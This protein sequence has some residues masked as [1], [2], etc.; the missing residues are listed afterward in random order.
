[1]LRTGLLLAFAL[2]TA[3]VTGCHDGE[4]PAHASANLS[5][6]APVSYAD[7]VGTWQFVYSDARRAAVEADLAKK[8]SDPAALA[9]AKKE[10]AEEAAA[11]E[12]ELTREG[13]FLSRVEGKEILATA[14][15][16]KGTDD[17]RGLVLTSPTHAEM[18]M[19][20]VLRDASTLIVSDP[21]KGELV[22]ARR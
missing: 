12:I 7:V 5:S 4:P 13:R 20:V 8:I 1:M 10:A 19:K 6:A 18:S 16:A 2:S 11:S 21:R 22:F 3:A 14:V 9:A 15:V 17:G